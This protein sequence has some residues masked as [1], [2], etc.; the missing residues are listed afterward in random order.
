MGTKYEP[1]RYRVRISEQGFGE[2]KEKKTPFFF[3]RIVPFAC[4]DPTT[5]AEPYTVESHERVYERYITDNT[6][7]YFIEDLQS[8]GYDRTKFSELDPVNDG[9]HSF[10]GKEIDAVCAHEERD[11][12][13]WERWSLAKAGGGKQIPRI[14]SKGVSKLDALYG[15]QLKAAIKTNGNGS[16]KPPKVSKAQ[17]EV[18]DEVPF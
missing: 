11:G 8:L 3:L 9:H 17:Q 18:G 4:Y 6:V 1:G 5:P 14:D 15:Q 13:K 16:S 2:S 10:V 12:D 7:K